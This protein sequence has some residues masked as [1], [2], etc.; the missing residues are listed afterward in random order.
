[1]EHFNGST[2]AGYVLFKFLGAMVA[3][4]VLGGQSIACSVPPFEI[5]KHHAELVRETEN[6]VLAKAT[7]ASEEER[8]IWGKPYYL[9]HFTTI[10][11]I[12]G[13][14][15]TQ[16]T[17]ENGFFLP[18]QGIGS[19]DLTG[20]SQLIFWDKDATRQWNMPDC[21]MRPVFFADRTY[22]L[23]LDHPHW[24]AYEEITSVDDLWLNAVQDLVADPQRTSGLSFSAMD[25]FSMAEGIFRGKIMNCAGPQ[26]KVEETF[27]G[28]AD[29][30]WAYTD[31]PHPGYWPLG[32]CNIGQEFIVLIL[33][34]PQSDLPYYSSSVFALSNGAIDI[35]QRSSEIEVQQDTISI[36]ELRSFFADKTE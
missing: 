20:H 7:G 3:F 32:T 6:I 15:P 4:M 14:A 21:Q 17:I 2:G 35:S 25:W 1:V 36:E 13:N 28:D 12:K 22:L 18:D 8:E 23:F 30:T 27:K 33:E 11:P 10:R 19:Q 5:T 9:A 24:R 29:G 34:E 26:L 16:F 31:E